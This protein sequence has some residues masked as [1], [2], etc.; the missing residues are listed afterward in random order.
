M[1]KPPD[2]TNAQRTQIKAALIKMVEGPSPYV[3]EAI[4]FA[5]S[6]FP[7]K[8]LLPL[9]ERLLTDPYSKTVKGYNGE[10]VLIYP[11]REAAKSSIKMIQKE[12]NKRPQ[13]Q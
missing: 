7:D 4:A 3:R 1:N 12:L 2:L 13:E 11:V 8:E 10:P 6:A 9:L 5:L